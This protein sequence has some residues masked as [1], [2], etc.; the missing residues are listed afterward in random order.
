LGRVVHI[1]QSREPS[2]RDSNPD[3]IEID[4]ET[5]KPSTLRELEAYVASCL[6]KKPRKPA[7]MSILIVVVLLLI[8]FT[9]SSHQQV[10]QLVS[11]KQWAKRKR[12]K[13]RRKRKNWKRDFRTFPANWKAPGQQHRLSRGRRMRS[14]GVSFGT[15][16]CFCCC[17]SVGDWDMI[18]QSACA[19]G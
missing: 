1:I 19:C 7:G 13:I 18:G 6:R 14:H 12:N 9:V 15:K 2:L 10:Q 11:R 3:E 5:L 4:F 17:L 16:C 8:T